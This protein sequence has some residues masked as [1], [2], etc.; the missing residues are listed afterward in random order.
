LGLSEREDRQSVGIANIVRRAKRLVVLFS[1]FVPKTRNPVAAVRPAPVSDG[2]A[3]GQHL[4]IG[5]AL[6]GEFRTSRAAVELGVSGGSGHGCFS[7][8]KKYGIPVGG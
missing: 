7:V 6:F 3:L 4:P 1:G 5:L 2:A 8:R